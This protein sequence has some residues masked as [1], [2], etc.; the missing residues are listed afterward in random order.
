MASWFDRAVSG[1]R[2]GGWN[3]FDPGNRF[4]VELGGS[5]EREKTLLSGLLIANPVE[6]FVSKGGSEKGFPVLD[7]RWWMGV[8]EKDQWRASSAF[9]VP[10]RSVG[11]QYE[12]P[13]PRSVPAPN[14][15][16]VPIS[17]ASADLMAERPRKQL[18]TFHGL[19]VFIV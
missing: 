12:A 16:C 19:R 17:R 13:S 10:A 4:V 9:G 2:R 7:V 18:C 1:S 5:V 3:L 8:S 6:G 11:N 15:A 14:P